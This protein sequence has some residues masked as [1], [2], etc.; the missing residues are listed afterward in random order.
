MIQKGHVHAPSKVSAQSECSH[1]SL[2]V[3]E[4][5]GAFGRGLAF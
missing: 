3:V 1:T 5:C 2:L 4:L